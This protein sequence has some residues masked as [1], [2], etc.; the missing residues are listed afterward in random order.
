MVWV[1]DGGFA[2]SEALEAHYKLALLSFFWVSSR[3]GDGTALSAKDLDAFR[4]VTLAQAADLRSE[5]VFRLLEP[6]CEGFIYLHDVSTDSALAFRGATWAYLSFK[7][8][9]R[10]LA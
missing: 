6:L 2:K 1:L 3:L 9:D 8:F 7:L 5:K 4:D 10:K